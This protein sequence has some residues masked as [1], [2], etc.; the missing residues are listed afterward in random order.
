MQPKRTE[1]SG[2]NIHYKPFSA[3]FV[4][5]CGRAK[6]L[7]IGSTRFPLEAPNMTTTT[8]AAPASAAH[9]T[10]QLWS[11]AGITIAVG[12]V[13]SLA[14]FTTKSPVEAKP[15]QEFLIGSW[16][17]SVRGPQGLIPFGVSDFHKDG[18]LEGTFENGVRYSGTWSFDNEEASFYIR[19]PEEQKCRAK[20]HAAS[21]RM[22]TWT[23]L[24]HTK[25]E[26]IG[27]SKIMFRIR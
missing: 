26:M 24:D 13:G 11:G 17:N 9:P 22:A 7:G 27:V 12:L 18:R 1:A 8:S 21:R 2:A 19:V 5:R 4:V 14:Y 6:R 3:G 10:K 20:I 16:K 25:P 23:Y 15:S